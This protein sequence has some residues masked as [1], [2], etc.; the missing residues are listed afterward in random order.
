MAVTVAE[1]LREDRDRF[2]GFAFANADLLLELD[3]GGRIHWAGG[4]VKSILEVEADGLSGQPLGKIL[5]DHDA[6]MLMASLRALGPG[7]RRRGITLNLHLDRGSAR[8]AQPCRPGT[9][10]VHG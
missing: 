7:Q 4:A 8:Q 6:V 10:E 2:V 5:A 1:R 9:T 3:G